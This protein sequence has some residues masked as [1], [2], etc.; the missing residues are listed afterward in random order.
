MDLN[1]ISKTFR[2]LGDA[3]GKGKQKDWVKVM[4]ALGFG[5]E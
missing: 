3:G 2:G 4:T 1:R 5:V